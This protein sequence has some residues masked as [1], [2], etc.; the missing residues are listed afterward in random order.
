MEEPATIR[1]VEARDID[2]LYAIALATGASGADAS[3]QYSDPR[4]VGHL[5]AAP[6]VR[7]SGESS[8]VVED[9]AGVGGYIV[10]ALDTRVFEAVLEDRWW[11]SLRPTY[12]DPSDKPPEKWTL[13]EI[14]A[15]QIHHPRPVPERVVGPYPSH[16]HINLLPRLQG[17]GLGRAL[18]DIWV[19]RLK[20]LGSTGAHLGVD[21][22]NARALKFYAAVGWRELAPARP[23]P[24]STVWFVREL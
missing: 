5:Y 7:F 12:R 8:F 21:P 3:N 23:G 24:V 13:D 1:P 15:W 9:R 14:R 10:G 18:I 20:A 19:A 4:M 22:A 17:Q 2:A 16:L 6:Y 11:P